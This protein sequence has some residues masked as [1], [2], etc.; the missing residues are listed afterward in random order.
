MTATALKR[1]DPGGDFLEHH[2]LIGS[3]MALVVLLAVGVS[4]G[5]VIG[6]LLVQVVRLTLDLLTDGS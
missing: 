1:R 4:A 6:S 3:M 2:R 5:G